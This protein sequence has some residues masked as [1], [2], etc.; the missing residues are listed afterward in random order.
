MWSKRQRQPCQFQTQTHSFSVL[1]NLS[2]GYMASRKTD[3]PLLLNAILGSKEA[4][5]MQLFSWFFLDIEVEV[6]DAVEDVKR[7]YYSVSLY[8]GDDKPIKSTKSKPRSSVVKWE[9]KANNEMW[10]V[11]WLNSRSIF[12]SQNQ[13]VRAV[14]ICEN[15]T[16]SWIPIR[17]YFQGSRRKVWRK[18]CRLARWVNVR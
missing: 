10:V 7:S 11:L 17:K 15:R 12:T 9:W 18:G 8:V 13:M 6:F 4:S 3:E 1:T 16:L 2:F 5:M 14:I